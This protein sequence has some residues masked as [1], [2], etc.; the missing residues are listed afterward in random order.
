MLFTSYE[1]LL[2]LRFLYSKKS[3]G[4][5]SIFSW[6]SKDSFEQYIIFLGIK[7]LIIDKNLTCK[8]LRIVLSD[9]TKS[10][11]I[12]HIILVVKVN[13][14]K[15]LDMTREWYKKEWIIFGFF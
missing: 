4:F 5:I 13:F 9:L 1:K 3:D 14:P 6:F 11:W 2:I 12:L 7:L 10:W 15:M 8:F